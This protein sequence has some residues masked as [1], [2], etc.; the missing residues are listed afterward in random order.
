MPP[1][2]P[3]KTVQEKGKGLEGQA[4]RVK[5]K[6]HHPAIYGALRAETPAV[7]HPLRPKLGERN[8]ELQPRGMETQE[9]PGLGGGSSV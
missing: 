3:P 8:L 2:S 5:G 4:G 6:L 9:K 7:T 1:P